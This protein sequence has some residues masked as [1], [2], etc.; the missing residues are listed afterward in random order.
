MDKLCVMC[1]GLYNIIISC[2][3]CGQIM[4]DL[5]L[6]QDYYGPYSAYEDQEIFEDGYK[7]YTEEC[8]VHLLHCHACGWEEFRP[9]HR[10]TEAQVTHID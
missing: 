10:F 3:N 7:G 1:N 5:G 6:I 2:P 4:Q 8:C 9:M